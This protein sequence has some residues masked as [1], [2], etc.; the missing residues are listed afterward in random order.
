MQ[1]A[2]LLMC[3][4]ANFDQVLKR[5]VAQKNVTA[6]ENFVAASIIAWLL[7]PPYHGRSSSICGFQTGKS[8]FSCS[9]G[10]LK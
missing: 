1:C 4:C 8:P 3:G 5:R 7:P 10:L 9:T 6:S 2:N